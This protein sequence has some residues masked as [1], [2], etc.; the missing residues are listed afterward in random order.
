MNAEAQCVLPARLSSLAAATAFVAAFAERCGLA[1]EDGLR[2][3]LVV[4][5]LF[6]NT[7]THGAQG[8]GDVEVRLTLAATP[9]QLRLVYEDNGPSFDPRAAVAQGQAGHE[10]EA[11]PRIGGLGLLL[12]TQMAT[13]I[14]YAR[15][16][17]W[18]RLTVELARCR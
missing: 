9:A 3:R 18:N 5:E 14:D 4:E 2:L 8:A 12:V 13:R 17:R 7:A 15:D 6:A 11:E 1:P 10:A 16:G